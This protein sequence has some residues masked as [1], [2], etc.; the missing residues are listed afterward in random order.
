MILSS[1]LGLP[2]PNSLCHSRFP[3]QLMINFSLRNFFIHQIRPL[4]V[5]PISSSAVCP[6]AHPYKP[7]AKTFFDSRYSQSICV[8]S[9][10]EGFYNAWHMSETL[11]LRYTSPPPPDRRSKLTQPADFQR[12]M[13]SGVTPEQQS[14]P[15]TFYSEG[16]QSG[17]TCEGLGLHSA[18]SACRLWDEN[19][20]WFSVCISIARARAHA[21][22]YT[23]NLYIMF[24]WQF[25]SSSV[26]LHQTL[27]FVLACLF[28]FMPS[29]C[30][31]QIQMRKQTKTADLYGAV[32]K[33]N[34]HFQI[35]PF[36]IF[37]PNPSQ[38]NYFTTDRPIHLN[39]WLE[40][41]ILL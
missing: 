6:P 30:A 5:V 10:Y 28:G 36:R 2:L 21:H 8:P 1:L 12:S 40:I 11:P 33:P 17:T 22:T 15:P 3:L 39:L 31:V 25:Y 23:H 19:L 38:N 16:K 34:Q 37:K 14:R 20:Q 26:L 27:Q 29:V 9:K 32:K 35:N 13:N 24:K 41:P 7:C 18:W 4:P